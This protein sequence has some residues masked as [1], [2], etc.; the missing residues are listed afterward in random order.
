MYANSE[1]MVVFNVK[2]ISTFSHDKNCE[3]TTV[4]YRVRK[5]VGA[6]RI[7]L[8]DILCFGR[9]EGLPIPAKYAIITSCLGIGLADLF[10]C[11]SKRVLAT[12]KHP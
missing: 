4:S 10:C 2:E 3:S 8:E 7:H 11:C 1:Y 9:T 6:Q 5:D 12:P